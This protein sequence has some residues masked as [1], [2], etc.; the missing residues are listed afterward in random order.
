MSVS[1]RSFTFWLNLNFSFCTPSTVLNVVDTTC[2]TLVTGTGA[3]GG[4]WPTATLNV[5]IEP[6]LADVPRSSRTCPLSRFTVYVPLSLA[7]Q[8][9]PGVV[10]MYVAIAPVVVF[11]ALLSDTG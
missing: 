4:V 5:P 3:G 7:S 6:D 1:D 10:T 8:F 2:G 11:T 9:W